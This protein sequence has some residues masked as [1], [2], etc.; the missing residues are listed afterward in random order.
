MS[1]H[2]PRNHLL[3]PFHPERFRQPRKLGE[4]KTFTLQSVEATQSTMVSV[5]G[6]NGKVLEY[7]PEVIPQTKWRQ[8][9]K[10]F[11]ITAMHAQRL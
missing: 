3:R 5:L 7:R 9:E 10:G 1:N 11:E 4:W 6:Q 2:L 8:T